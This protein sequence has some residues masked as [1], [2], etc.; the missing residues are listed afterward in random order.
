MAEQWAFN[1]WVQGSTPWRPTS[2]TRLTGALWALSG[3]WLLEYA[4]AAHGEQRPAHPAGHGLQAESCWYVRCGVR[5]RP[6]LAVPVLDQQ[7]TLAHH[8][9]VSRA[10]GCDG[11]QIPGWAGDL[12]PAGA[13]EV[14]DQ[15]VAY[16]PHVAGGGAAQGG[17]D[18][19]EGRGEGQAP[20]AAVPVVQER[21]RAAA[22]SRDA[23]QAQRPRAAGGGRIDRL[24]RVCARWGGD[25][26]DVPAGAVP[27][28]D[29]RP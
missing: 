9:G 4:G 14:V 8:P 6:G 18:R 2:R 24:H 12:G 3:V 27:V 25:L 26:G 28:L 5:L 15:P 13:V 22:V 1:P 23:A 11:G 17:E 19:P 7:A 10:E 20:V 29:Q 21:E 16:R